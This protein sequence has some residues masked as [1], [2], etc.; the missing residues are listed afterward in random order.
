MKRWTDEEIEILKKHYKIKSQQDLCHMLINRTWCAVLHKAITLGCVNKRTR[1][2]EERFWSFVDKKSSDKCW[3]WTGYC[4]KGGYGQF[5]TNGK[6]ITAHRFSWILHNSKISKNEQCVLHHCDN[7]KCVNP[8]HLWI[9]TQI[10][11]ILDMKKKNRQAK[12]KG[13]DN[14]NAKL[15]LDQVKQIR[16]LK[17]KLLLKEIA[18][19]FNVKVSAISKIHLN[20]TWKQ[21]T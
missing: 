17:G 3:N 13:E 18:Q 7:P 20:K 1:T 21:T 15:T 2:I 12:L 14:G 11:N 10:E 8:N 4:T 9:G 5:N 16:E 19:L 6:M